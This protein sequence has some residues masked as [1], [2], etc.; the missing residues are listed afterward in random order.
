[1]DAID[2]FVL[3][4]E[5]LHRQVE[6]NFLHRL[7]DTQL[8][9]RPQGLN[10]I[11]W[12]VWHMARCE[13]MLSL[14][15]VGRPQVLDEE[16]W[17]PRLHLSVRDIG[18]GMSDDEVS[19]LSARLNLA[20]L[21]DYY[22]AVGRRTLEVVRSLRPEALDELPDLH[23]LRAAGL[24][25]ENALAVIEQREGQSKGQWLGQLGVSHSQGHRGQATTICL[26]Q[27][28]RPR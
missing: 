20:A 18:T 1:M 22:A 8:R 25:R 10:S 3:Q 2:F 5:R 6:H 9:L 4:H 24:V 11:A 23:R 13:D 14:V 26:L 28:I 7:S 15:L 16:D 27:G 19:D 21:R 17:L 12:L